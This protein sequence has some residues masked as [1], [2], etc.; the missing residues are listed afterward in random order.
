MVDGTVEGTFDIFETSVWSRGAVD[1][2]GKHAIVVAFT[3]PEA[4]VVTR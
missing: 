1:G 4:S 2:E 3:K